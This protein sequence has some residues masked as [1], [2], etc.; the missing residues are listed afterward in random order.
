MP[1]IH[2]AAPLR[3]LSKRHLEILKNTAFS[4]FLR[5]KTAPYMKQILWAG[6]CAIAFLLL[7]SHISE[8]K[9]TR[10]S[11]LIEQPLRQHFE[12]QNAQFRKAML[13][14]KNQ[15]QN[16]KTPKKGAE[17]K[18]LDAFRQLRLAYKHIELITAY[19]DP[20]STA[21]L[22]GPAIP[23]AEYE[24]Y[25]AT[26]RPSYSLQV[27]EELLCDENPTQHR[28]ELLQ[29]ADKALAYHE[30]MTQVV[31]KYPLE[32]WML[33]DALRQQL[34]RICAL[35]LVGFD[36]PVL[37]HSLPETAVALE[38][39][40]YVVQLYEPHLLDDKEPFQQ[41]RAHLHRAIEAVNAARSFDELD[42]VGLL[43]DHLSPCWP[44]LYRL[45]QAL[46]IEPV[47]QRYPFHT[48]YNIQAS[49]LFAPDFLKR[50]F[51]SRVKT[52]VLPPK[53]VALGRLLF[54]DPILSGNGERACASCHQPEYAF[55]EPVRFS[56][57]F[58]PQEHIGRNAPTLINA[59][60]SRL[61]QMD[62]RASSIEEQFH[63]VLVN[64]REMNIREHE[65]IQRIA[66]SAEYRRLFQ[67]AFGLPEGQQPDFVLIKAALSAYVESLTAFNSPIDRYMRG[68]TDRIDPEA[69]RGFNLFLGKAKCATCH[70]IP[71][72]NGTVPPTFQETEVEVLG[73]P[74]EK[75][76]P[77]VSPDL[78]RYNIAHLEQ[79]RHAFKT[80]TVRNAAFTA[81]YMHNGVFSTLEELVL[82]YNHGGGAGMGIELENQTL[83]PD[84]LHLTAREVRALVRFMEALTDTAGLTQRP[85]RLPA[86]EGEYAR[87]NDRPIGGRY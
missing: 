79:H 58:E 51:F 6:L 5:Q 61:F 44:W 1:G 40:L 60:Y 56:R 76:T 42:R 25:L 15:I 87:W 4:N 69:Y 52:Q 29:L 48:A 20:Y 71:L 77:K 16:T 66:A 37:L 9:A 18:W 74:A 2:A 33:F 45:Q 24:G 83:P 47:E 27:V 78:G 28:T 10:H 85:V 86:L 36:S 19:F 3:P 62:G 81:P 72:T 67:E 39:M 70:F 30:D 23:K 64:E 41:L 7:L 75:N 59:L 13:A 14:F 8:E 65:A 68:E 80:P 50:G 21:Q 26:S 54:F 49:S 53:V 73:T 38:E 22:N 82:F 31:Q 55:A 35:G 43:R 12:A 63:Q 46:G 57:A 84:S 17:K 34:V 11:R 32:D